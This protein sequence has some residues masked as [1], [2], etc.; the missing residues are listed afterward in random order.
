MIHIEYG[1]GRT[2]IC[3]RFDIVTIFNYREYTA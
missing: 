1:S 3:V 2:A